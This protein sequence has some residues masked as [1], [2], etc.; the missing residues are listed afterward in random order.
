MNCNMTESEVLETVFILY[1]LDFKYICEKQ[2]RVD[3]RLI[4]LKNEKKEKKNYLSIKRPYS[5]HKMN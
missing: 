4:R 3:I 1:F 2:H 5:M